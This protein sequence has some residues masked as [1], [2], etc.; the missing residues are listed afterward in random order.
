MILN[1]VPLIFQDMKAKVNFVICCIKKRLTSLLFLKLE[2]Q[3][4]LFFKD[5]LI[6][7]SLQML[8]SNAKYVSMLIFCLS[9]W[10]KKMHLVDHKGLFVIKFLFVSK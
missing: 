1:S 7:T 10:T 6:K 5:F 2:F 4:F 8:I 3:I 9:K